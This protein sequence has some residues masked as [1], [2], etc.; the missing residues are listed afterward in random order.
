MRGAQGDG[1]RAFFFVEIF[2]TN[3]GQPL[4]AARPL[5]FEQLTD[6]VVGNEV[7]GHVGHVL[8]LRHVQGL[9]TCMLAG[10]G[11]FQPCVARAKEL[12]A[13]TRDFQAHVMKA[14]DHLQGVAATGQVQFEL[15]QRHSTS[16]QVHALEP[17]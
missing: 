8:Q 14:H 5:G 6:L 11:E 12:S 7:I 17:G 15:I 1:F 16:E 10:E 13:A 2:G 3:L 9:L 4:L